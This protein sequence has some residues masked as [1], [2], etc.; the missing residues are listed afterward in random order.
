MIKKNN[1]EIDEWE[2]FFK[3]NKKILHL[4]PC[5]NYLFLMN[6]SFKEYTE[7]AFKYYRKKNPLNRTH[8]TIQV[9]LERLERR[10][11]SKI[12]RTA[13]KNWRHTFENYSKQTEYFACSECFV[14]NFFHTQFLL[15]PL[16]S[17]S[18]HLSLHLLSDKWTCIGTRENRRENANLS[19]NMRGS[20]S[21]FAVKL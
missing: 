10:K 2:I 5:T 16:S 1:S 15:S 4:V 21:K 3:G 8:R 7:A 11:R 12:Q 19:Y 18:L 20:G 17:L 13:R 9:H 6:F 14:M